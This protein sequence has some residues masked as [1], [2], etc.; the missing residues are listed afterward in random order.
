MSAAVA[1]DTADSH[2]CKRSDFAAAVVGKDNKGKTTDS[3]EYTTRSYT[4]AHSQVISRTLS[5]GVRWYHR[6]IAFGIPALLPFYKSRTCTKRRWSI[7]K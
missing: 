4:I 2:G 6:Y 3:K 5:L 1:Q 7:G